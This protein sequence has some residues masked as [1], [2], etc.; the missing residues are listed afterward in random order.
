MSLSISARQ[1]LYLFY[2]RMQMKVLGRRRWTF[3]RGVM[4]LLV[5]SRGEP[6]LFPLV[7]W[8]SGTWA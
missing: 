5:F 1:E 3:P 4:E 6:G 8:S 7:S 2:R